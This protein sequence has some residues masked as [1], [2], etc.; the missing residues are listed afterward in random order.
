MAY[1]AEHVANCL[2]DDSDIE[3]ET[4]S[5]IEEDPDFPLPTIDSDDEEEVPLPTA[6]PRRGAALYTK[7]NA[8]NTC[9]HDI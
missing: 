8:Y 7:E 6:S 5:E 3:A 9:R 2:L 4:D 1:T